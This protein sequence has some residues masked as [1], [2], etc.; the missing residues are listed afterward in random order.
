MRRDRGVRDRTTAPRAPRD[1]V[2]A[3]APQRGVVG[4]TD[5]AAQADGLI[6][7]M[8]EALMAEGA[9]VDGAVAPAGRFDPTAL[10]GRRRSR[11][12][13]PPAP[14][15]RSMGRPTRAEELPWLPMTALSQLVRDGEVE[16]RAVVEAYA[17]RLTRLN[18]TLNAFITPTVEA[19]LEAAP[20]AH[21][22]RLAGVPMAIKDIIEVAGTRTTAGSRLLSDHVSSR[23][24]PVWQR[25]RAEGAL[26]I[27]KSHTHEFAGGATGTSEAY[28][29]ARNPWA[30]G[31]ITGG[32]SSGSGAAVAAALAS[33]ALGTDTG[34]SIRIPAALCGVVGLKPTYGRVDTEGVYPL[35]WSL[36]HV[37][38][39]ARTVRDAARLLD[40]LAPVAGESCEDAAVAGAAGA[41]GGVR[42]GVPRPWLARGIQPAVGR[43][44]DAALA[45]LA[46]RGGEVDGF[47]PP[48][49][50]ELMEAVGSALVLAEASAWH[51]PFVAAGR[52]GEYGADVRPWF[53]LGAAL[54][55]TLYVQAQRLRASLAAR[56]AAVWERFDVIAL[57]TVPVE[58]P[59]I[60]S[61]RVG[62]GADGASAPTEET[63]LAW[64]NPVDV[65]GAPAVSVPCGLT[66]SGLPVGLQLAAA[67]GEDA[68]LCWVAASA[69]AALGGGLGRPPAARL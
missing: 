53:A 27:G 36:D 31:R 61:D 22:G 15:D 52:A 8:R 65:L 34:G 40:V 2:A 14:P 4:V 45:A 11:G 54:P 5:L 63:L 62:L 26:L 10:A 39:L 28:G 33:A 46:D 38:P 69:E 59:P 51:A 48:A 1:G 58:A 57:P 60:G 29:P 25:L 43:A 13:W 64:T 21:R 37:G 19:A 18:P 20:R 23:D 49:S 44:F 32:S 17:A 16:P 50:L 56:F 55:A 41:L 35:S 7:P 68:F 30:T 67:P 12:P 42:F 24:A 66:P 6:G 47:A 3:A 9:A